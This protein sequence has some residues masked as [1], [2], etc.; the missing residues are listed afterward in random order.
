[1]FISLCL[2][3]RAWGLSNETPYGLLR[4]CQLAKRRGLS[5][6]ASCQVHYNLLLRNDV[7][8]QFVE[9]SRPQNTGKIGG[10]PIP[11]TAAHRGRDTLMPSL[12]RLCLPR[13]RRLSPS[14]PVSS[15]SVC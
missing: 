10:D 9:A 11:N 14:S 3:I 15:A 4:F 5:P 2:Q 12:V 8:K 6:P 1:M 13:L 7:E